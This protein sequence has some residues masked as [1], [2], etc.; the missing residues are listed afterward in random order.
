MKIDPCEHQDDQESET[1]HGR[2]EDERP[3]ENRLIAQ[4]VHPEPLNEE[5]GTPEDQDDR[6]QHRQ[7]DHPP[8]PVSGDFPADSAFTVLE[9]WFI[10]LLHGPGI[11]ALECHG[12][13]PF[14][15]F[16]R[17]SSWRPTP[18]KTFFVPPGRAK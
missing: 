3:P 7:P 6:G 10:G 9:R 18:L 17:P 12:T 8:E 4:P 2:F 11:I 14:R 16:F 15:C 1:E 5:I 13:T